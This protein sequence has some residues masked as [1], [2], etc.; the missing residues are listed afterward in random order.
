[1]TVQTPARDTRV[2]R[3]KAR[4][5]QAL[6]DAAKRI[7]ANRGT[8]DISIQEITDEADIGFG[9]F[10]NY[11]DT[12]SELFATAVGEVLDAYGAELDAASESTDDWAERYAI[13]VRLTSRLAVDQPAVAKILAV[14]GTRYLLSDSGLAPRARRDIEQ[15]L[16]TGRFDVGSTD[17]ALVNTA[18]CMIA[19]VSVQMDAPDKLSEDDAD[20]LAEQLLRMLGLSANDA[21]EVAHR[22]L[23]ALPTIA[24]AP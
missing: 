22:P 5:R 3:R 23:P 1:V 17:V 20:E 4:T 15:G 21:H 12:K 11:F 7:L 16:A 8:T 19:F 24:A 10:Y 2:G 13:G 18:G 14:S 9:S 6:V